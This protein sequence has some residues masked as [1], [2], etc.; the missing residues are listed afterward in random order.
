MKVGA[1]QKVGELWRAVETEPRRNLGGRVVE[2]R[3][4]AGGNG[5]GFSSGKSKNDKDTFWGHILHFKAS[6]RNN[7]PFKRA[8]KDFEGTQ[9]NLFQNHL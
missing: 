3:N 5:I 6:K 1:R 8:K 4:D 9:K 2:R 7:V